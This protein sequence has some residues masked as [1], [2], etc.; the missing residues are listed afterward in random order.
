MDFNHNP[1]PTQKDRRP[2]QPPRIELVSLRPKETVLGGCQSASLSNNSGTTDQLC[3]TAL[4][5]Q[6]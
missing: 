4:C 1:S 6:G 2:Y 3:T 5:L